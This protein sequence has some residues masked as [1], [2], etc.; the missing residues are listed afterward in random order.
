MLLARIA[1]WRDSG[2]YPF[3][4]FAEKSDD[5]AELEGMA[6][7]LRERFERVAVIGVGGAS[8]GGQAVAALACDRG[9]GATPLSF[10]DNPD[11]ARL[12]AELEGAAETGF[13]VISKSGATAETLAL[14]LLA[15]AA[16]AHLA[17]QALRSGRVVRNRS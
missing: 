6:L 13:I 16:S 2:D 5:L 9:A 3:L 17:N 1:G 8:L 12:E 15:A 11:A 7:R 4:R 10:L 14:T